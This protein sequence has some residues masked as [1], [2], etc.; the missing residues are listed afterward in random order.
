MK[1]IVQDR[2]GS[3]D[4]LRL[5]EIDRAAVGGGDVLVRVRAAS[6][7]PD[8]WHVLRGRPYLLRL[9][10]A[11]LRRPA[12]RVPG[13]DVAGIVEEV[14]KRVTRFRPGDAVFGECVRGH[15]WHNGGAY[16]EF[17]A[18]REAALEPKPAG[19]TFE[20][21]AAVPTSGLIALRS[22]RDEGGLR[23]GQR[24]L[25]N[26]A[27][28]GVGTFAVQIA[29]ALGATVTA[30]DRAEKLEMLRSIGADRVID[31]AREDFTQSGDRHDVLLDI[32]GNRS[33]AD[34]RRAL[35]PKGT[36]VL[37]GHDGFGRSGNRWIGGVSRFL[38]VLAVAPFV[39]QR[40]VPR[41]AA[42]AGA[43]L[44]TL[45]ELIEAGKVRPVVD[46]TFPLREVPE[47]IHYMEQGRALGK[48]V[49][50]V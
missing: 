19:L 10:G 21:A 3:T 38:R 44:A 1:A 7:H 40:M 8:V 12:N 13:T 11:G 41:R 28:G 2:Y 37:V 5:D 27:G 32:P 35:E 36:Y 6:M 43:P 39:S 46:R 18:V 22:L 45:R 34:C 33:L 42:P 50:T 49:I 47:A 14:G 20:E 17:V 24:V 23:A 25:I 31:H 29:K 16:A 15:Q 9:M 4:V 26:G 30:V 48:I